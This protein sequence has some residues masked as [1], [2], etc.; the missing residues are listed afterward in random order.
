ML[1]IYILAQ[2]PLYPR[3]PDTQRRRTEP[4]NIVLSK[5]G[6]VVV[7][8]SSLLLETVRRTVTRWGYIVL[9]IHLWCFC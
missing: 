1:K 7:A 2:L 5:A 6:N 4:Y 9:F 3:V 8:T